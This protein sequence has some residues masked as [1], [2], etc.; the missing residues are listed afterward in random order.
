MAQ[1][2][3]TI[4]IFWRITSFILSQPDMLFAK[5]PASC[6]PV[7]L[8]ASISQEAQENAKQQF[9]LNLHVLAKHHNLTRSLIHDNDIEGLPD[10]QVVCTKTKHDFLVLF[11]QA[12]LKTRVKRNGDQYVPS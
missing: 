5:R 3:D 1:K 11:R 10:L 12:W 2:W 4:D 8:C 7:L 6:M 9:Y